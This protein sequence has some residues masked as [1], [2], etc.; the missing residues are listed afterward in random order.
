MPSELADTLLKRR[1]DIDSKS[2]TWESKPE[3]SSA[4]ASQHLEGIVFDG[5]SVQ[6]WLRSLGESPEEDTLGEALTEAVEERGAAPQHAPAKVSEQDQRRLKDLAEAVVTM[7]KQF[8]AEREKMGEQKE[9]LARREAEIRAKEQALEAEREAQREREEAR[10]NYPSPDW[11]ENVEG[12]M[13]VAVVG[14]AGVG[15]SLLI[16]KLRR[17]RPGSVSWAPVGVN[18]TTRSPTKYEFSG[19]NR[20]RLWD[21]PGAGTA[22]FPSETYIQTMGLR[23][24]DSVLIITA[25]RFTS[26]EVQ[27][28]AELRTH[29]VPFYMIRTK[30]DI[31]IW[32][33][34][35]D[36]NLDEPATL[37]QIRD[38][39]KQKSSISDPYLV[40]SRDPDAYDFQRLMLDVF[41]CVKRT[42]DSGAPCFVPGNN[43]WNDSWALPVVFTP[44]IQAIQGRWLDHYG[45]VYL[46]QGHDTH[47]T[48]RDGQ[49]AVVV[50]SEANGCAWWMNRWWITLNNVIRSRNQVDLRWS[51]RNLQDKPLVWRW[52]D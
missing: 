49:S 46:I 24:F 47:V 13:N 33:N 5:P 8:N 43:S 32:N 52:V 12:T 40:S 15:K 42:L 10:K 23:Y 51:P 41:P 11:L 17:I 20:V 35:Q 19:E 1:E 16:N 21:L 37:Q 29:N 25:G 36:N 39:L 34:K 2:Q 45:A 30:V 31:D 26:T 50:L 27:L 18:E 28:M 38:D 14:N 4:D 7:Q 9:E 44:V 22:D 3:S 6:E 48:L